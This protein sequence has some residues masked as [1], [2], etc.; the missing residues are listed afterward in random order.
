MRPGAAVDLTALALLASVAETGSL[1]QAAIRHGLSQPAVSMRMTALERAVGVTLLR[2]DSSGTRLTPA[3]EQ[4]LA[5]ARRVLAAA[6][7]LA[8]VTERLRAEAA[9]RLR[10]AASFTVAEHLAPT[11]IETLRATA[12][13]VSLS[14]EVHN[15]AHVLDAVGRRQVDLGFVEG[16]DRHLPGLG[17]EVVTS[18]ELVVV[19]APQHPWASRTNPLTAAELAA[20]ELVVRERGSGTREVLERALE[21]F[22][23]I[24]TRLELGSTEAV[25][26]AARANDG[27]AVLSHLAAAGPVAQGLLTA[28]T[29]DGLDLRRAIRA[30]WAADT[31]LGTLARRLVDAARSAPPQG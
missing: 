9:G 23:G 5:A 14:L 31:G 24:R 25:L 16:V 4:V 17:S 7:T 28:V 1:G 3:G 13:E 26:A 11:W 21:P 19:V 2:R 12:P 30:V 6:D 18:D 20:T 22:G 29:V 27:P 8:Q 15:S 10:V